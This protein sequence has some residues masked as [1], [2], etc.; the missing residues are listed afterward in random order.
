MTRNNQLFFHIL[1]G[2]RLKYETDKREH[3]TM[4]CKQNRAKI[5]V[6]HFI[7]FAKLD[8]ISFFCLTH[9]ICGDDNMQSQT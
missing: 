3:V 7:I 8:T 6:P 1:F 2:I 5:L 9:F 4:L